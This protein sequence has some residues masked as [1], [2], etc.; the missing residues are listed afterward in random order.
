MVIQQLLAFSA[1]LVACLAVSAQGTEFA[2]YKLSLTWPASACI[3]TKNCKTPIP[4]F[5]TIHGL[6]PT[7]KSDKPVPPYDATTNKCNVNPVRPQ[8][9]V[10]KL[11]TIRPRLETK[12]PNLRVGKTDDIFWETEWAHHGMCSDYPQDPLTYFDVTL[13]LSNL[14][15]PLRVLGVQ[16]SN[17]P[18][19]IETLLENVYKNLGAYPQ[20]SCNMP[21]KGK[22]LYLKEIRFCFKRARPPF[23]LR[24]CT[25]DMD[26]MCSILEFRCL[27][28]SSRVLSSSKQWYGRWSGKSRFSK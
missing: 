13:N 14:Y 27:C 4:K 1:V 19:P 26:D 15:D 5:F 22:Q 2:I 12:W 17:T 20:I 18:H 21:V 8:D 10:P 3:P 9:L 6:W 16:P 7:Y 24:N 23:E 28:S 11:A 25:V